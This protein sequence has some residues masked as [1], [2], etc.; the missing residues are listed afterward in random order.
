MKTIYRAHDGIEFENEFDCI[1]HE[2]KSALL[3][4]IKKNIHYTY[5]D[6]HGVGVIEE[7]D[8]ERYITKYFAVINGLLKA[9]N[10]R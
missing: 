10:D 1:A 2:S 3:T 9:S 4:H 7:D 8:V 5:N 6:D